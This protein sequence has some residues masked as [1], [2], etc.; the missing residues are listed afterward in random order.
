MPQISAAASGVT[1]TFS[2]GFQT[3]QLPI[4]ISGDNLGTVALSVN[5][6]AATTINAGV[7]EINGPTGDT[8]ALTINGGTL[9]LNRAYTDTNIV[10][11]G[12]NGGTVAGT[13]IGSTLSGG[14]GGS[15]GL[16][17]GTQNVSIYL[18]GERS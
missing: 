1:V 8:G 11:L 13:G 4:V 17:I 12:S 16:T 10:T 9:L 3:T 14:I 18:T 6:G 5:D 2:G 7:L 15:G